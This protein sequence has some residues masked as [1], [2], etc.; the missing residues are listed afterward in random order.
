VE[1]VP[2]L[3]PVEDLNCLSSPTS[4][5]PIALSE[6]L[7]I[8][9]TE[10]MDRYFDGSDALDRK[11]T[12]EE[13]ESWLSKEAHRMSTMLERVHQNRDDDSF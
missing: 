2:V 7:G 13:G 1:V 11:R 4:M 6:V 8:S 3:V 9:L 10:V 5:L 12:N